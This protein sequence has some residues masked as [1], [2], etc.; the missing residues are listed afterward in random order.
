MDIRGIIKWKTIQW[1]GTKMGDLLWSYLVPPKKRKRSYNKQWRLFSRKC[2]EI[3]WNAMLTTNDQVAQENQL[4]ETSI[5]HIRL[6]LTTT[7]TDNL[8]PKMCV[9]NHIR[10]IL[11]IYS[12]AQGNWSGP[13][14]NKNNHRASISPEHPGTQRSLGPSRVYPQIHLK[15]V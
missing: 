12:L 7:T 13:R 15:F 2:L 5:Y 3:W 9:L 11:G 14:Q 6:T 8:P 10:Q 1:R 4:A